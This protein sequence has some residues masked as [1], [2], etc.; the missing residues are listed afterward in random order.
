MGKKSFGNGSRI[1]ATHTSDNDGDSADKRPIGGGIVVPEGSGIFAKNHILNPM[2]AIF[3]PPVPANPLSELKCRSSERTDVIIDLLIRFSLPDTDSLY[4]D[5]TLESD[6]IEV[7]AIEV[8]KDTSL[9]NSNFSIT[10]D[11]AVRAT[12][13]ARPEPSLLLGVGQLK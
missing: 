11:A 7:N 6:P 1:I 2:Q 5:Q 13:R 8:I 4:L 10:A 12:K 3:N 9:S